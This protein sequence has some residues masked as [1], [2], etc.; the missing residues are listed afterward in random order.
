MG[1]HVRVLAGVLLCVTSARACWGNGG[2]PYNDVGVAKCNILDDPTNTIDTGL[3]SEADAALQSAL[4]QQ[5][6]G[7]AALTVWAFV[8]KGQT[9]QT[10]TWELT[11]SITMN[12]NNVEIGPLVAQMGAAQPVVN[13]LVSSGGSTFDIYQVSFKFGSNVNFNEYR[14]PS[15]NPFKLYLRLS[16]LQSSTFNQFHGLMMTSFPFSSTCKCPAAA[17]TAA[18]TPKMPYPFGSETD[19]NTMVTNCCTLQVR[20]GGCL[21][22]RVHTAQRVDAL[23]PPHP[24]PPSP[25]FT[26]GNAHVGY[27]PERV[28]SILALRISEMLLSSSPGA[29][30]PSLKHTFN[31]FF[32]AS[33]RPAYASPRY[34][35]L[36]RMST[37]IDAG[38]AEAVGLV[39]PFSIPLPTGSV[40]Y[41]EEGKSDASTPV[42]QSNQLSGSG[43]ASAATSVS[44]ASAAAAWVRA[45]AAAVVAAAAPHA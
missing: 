19:G 7:A 33:P 13:A 30:D 3:S 39:A 12:G 42:L 6:I 25:Q 41:L 22:M 18:Q 37:S 23:H 20:G 1:S 29:T 34:A 38:S 5:G 17:T 32:S 36:A 28:P 21:P 10:L 44:P 27:N 31:T 2:G 11:T 4:S 24:Y 43:K 35:F 40:G 15:S 26:N 45:A 14:G 16:N 8:P 9:F